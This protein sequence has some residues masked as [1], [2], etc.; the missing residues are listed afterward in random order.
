MGYYHR[1]EK[2]VAKHLFSNE[3]VQKIIRECSGHF[4]EL[5]YKEDEKEVKKV[6]YI[7]DSDCKYEFGGNF[8]MFF[9]KGDRLVPE[10][11]SPAIHILGTK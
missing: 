1:D 2:G 7:L 8:K 10:K 5:L 4:E 11:E 6:C 3:V 9:W